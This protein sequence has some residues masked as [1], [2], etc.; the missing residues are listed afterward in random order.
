ML[1]P[2]GLRVNIKDSSTRHIKRQTRIAWDWHC[3]QQIQ[4]RKGCA[5]Q[6]FDSDT[7]HKLIK[8]LTDRQ[9]KIPALT[10][11]AGWQSNGG[12][13]IW[14]ATQDPKCTWCGQ[15]DTH[16]HQMLRCPAFQH[17]RDQHNTA[18]QFMQQHPRTC[19]FPLPVHSPDIAL[20]RHC[21]SSSHGH[22][23]RRGILHRWVM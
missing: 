22:T 9:R 7:T 6:P 20:L 21:H 15:V 8:T 2:G 18:A 23:T 17:V 3:F 1:G 14:S 12:L 10:K 11:T 4:H 16:T 13:A 5:H 19:W